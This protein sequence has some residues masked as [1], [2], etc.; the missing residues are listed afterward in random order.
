MLQKIL[1]IISIMFSFLNAFEVNTH[2][3][4]TRCAITNS[5]SNGKAENLFDFGSFPLS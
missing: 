4:L 3:A 1:T 2:Q 5:C